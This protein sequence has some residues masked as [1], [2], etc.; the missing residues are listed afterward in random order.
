[1]DTQFAHNSSH[2]PQFN[3]KM[4]QRKNIW[5]D[6]FITL[7]LINKHNG[8]NCYIWKNGGTM[9]RYFIKNVPIYGYHPP[10]ITL[11]LKG[12]YKVHAMEDH[13]EHQQ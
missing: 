12:K 9:L 4:R 3:G 13:I 6:I 2:H 10:F 5:K 11:T 1:M 7:H 8:C